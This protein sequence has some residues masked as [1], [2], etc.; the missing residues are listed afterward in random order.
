MSNQQAKTIKKDSAD[1]LNYKNLAAKIEKKSAVI[2]VV[3]LGYVGLPLAVAFAEANFHVTGIDADP[4]KVSKLNKGI[5]YLLDIESERL[6]ATVK[7]GFLKATTEGS[8]LRRADAIIICVPTPLTKTKEP[9]LSFIVE[10]A[11]LI[12][13]Y[14][15]SGQ[16]VILE[17][18]TYPGTTREVVLPLLESTGLQ[19][20]IDY[21]LTFSPERIDPGSKKFTIKNTPKVVGGMEPHSTKLAAMLY[22]HVSEKVIEVSTP[23]AAEMDK[24]FENVFRS[25]NIA[26]VNE[27]AKLCERMNI[28]VWEVIKAASSKP[29]GYMAFYPGPGVGGHCIPLDPYYLAAKAKEYNF[30][31]RFIELAAEINETMPEYIVTSTIEAL[32]TTNKSLKGSKVLILGVAYKK[33]IEDLRESPSERILELLMERG[34]DVSYHDPY[35]HEVKIHHK[36]LKSIK[37]DK[38]ALSSYDCVVIA[39]DHSSYDLDF[40]IQNSKLVFD[41]R[42]C[43][44]PRKA[45]NLIRLG[46]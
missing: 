37:L 11:N 27:L 23:E 14:V 34:T 32:N 40:I 39:T 10:A 29:F 7:S 17:S 35:I 30:H 3:G 20:G 16:L 6:K 26:M 2:G 18:T 22:K 15:R 21:F 46:E 12:A 41:T 25:V 28:S 5:S 42:G 43:T 31:T 45:A 38:K 8:A 13:R 44:I 36:T 33:D 24:V 4:Q 19:V 9:D 1:V